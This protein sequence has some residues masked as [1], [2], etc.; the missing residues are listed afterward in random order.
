MLASKALV[1]V[2]VEQV[3]G[4]FR[5][6]GLQHVRV[7]VKAAQLCSWFG[8]N[9]YD[10]IG[11]AV[12]KPYSVLEYGTQ[13]AEITDDY[14]NGETDEHIREFCWKDVEAWRYRLGVD[15]WCQGKGTGDIVHQLHRAFANYWSKHAEENVEVPLGKILKIEPQDYVMASQW[16]GCCGAKSGFEMMNCPNASKHARSVRLCCRCSK[17][18]SSR[19]VK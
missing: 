15:G 18:T 19:I 14:W 9:V 16:S 1:N 4:L 10:W 12:N 11:D 13:L 17:S 3:M 8:G 6:R 7:A 2:T 5:C